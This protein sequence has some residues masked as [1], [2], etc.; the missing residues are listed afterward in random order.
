MNTILITIGAITTGYS[1]YKTAKYNNLRAYYKRK[2]ERHDQLNEQHAKLIEDFETHKKKESEVLGN[3]S[4]E[5]RRK[6]A[7]ILQKNT[8]IQKQSDKIKDLETELND[9]IT[10]HSMA[11]KEVT[12]LNNII[13]YFQTKMKGNKQFEQLVNDLKGGNE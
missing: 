10:T 6:D 4:T 1:I 12:K 7:K 11:S 2:C 8:L 5:N 13:N 3:I 9:L